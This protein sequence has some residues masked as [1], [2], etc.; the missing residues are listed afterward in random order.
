[1]AEH[2]V[3]YG[4]EV[5]WLIGSG[6]IQEAAMEASR[7]QVLSSIAGINGET[8]QIRRWAKVRDDATHIYE[9]LDHPDACAVQGEVSEHD[10]SSSCVGRR[11]SCASFTRAWGGT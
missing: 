8:L 10:A 6:S 5:Q 7:R 1:M 9:N 2:S 3:L 4:L 11:P